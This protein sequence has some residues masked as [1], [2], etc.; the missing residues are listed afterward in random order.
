MSR[1]RLLATDR[2]RHSGRAEVCPSAPDLK[3]SVPAQSSSSFNQIEP[4]PVRHATGRALAPRSGSGT[5]RRPLRSR[6]SVSYRIL[7]LFARRHSN[8]ASRACRSSATSLA[9]ITR[10]CCWQDRIADCNRAW[11]MMSCGENGGKAPPD[12]T[13]AARIGTPERNNDI[14]PSPTLSR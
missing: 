10:S 8:I 7:I 2:W 12:N 1:V 11:V 4:N 6:R 5:S 3:S 9:L 13:T 14:R